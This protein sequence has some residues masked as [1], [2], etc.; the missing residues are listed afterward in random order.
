MNWE[1]T[2]V[3]YLQEMRGQALVEVLDRSAEGLL[4]WRS[5]EHP[6]A[7]FAAR[8]DWFVWWS[9][10]SDGEHALRVRKALRQVDD[11]YLDGV[12]FPSG[13]V[14]R[15]CLSPIWLPEQRADLAAWEQRRPG[16]WARRCVQELLDARIRGE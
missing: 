3:A 5:G 12:P 15:L 10:G 1:P 13:E 14:R 7:A 6:C 4:L 16:D 8:E 9:L 2:I 11:L